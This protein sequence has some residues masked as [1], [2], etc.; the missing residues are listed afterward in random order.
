MKRII[1]IMTAVTVGWF[2]C[3]SAAADTLEQLIE[4]VRKESAKEKREFSER[5]ERF[6]NERDQQQRLLQEAKAQLEELQQRSDTL[7]SSYEENAGSIDE[8]QSQLKQRMGYLD[9][10]HG[11][12]R[13]IASDIQASLENSMVS[14]Q[15][16]RPR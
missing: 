6:K 12:I 13:Q 10:L 16:T 5:V 1:L 11:V 9:E 8:Q 4:Q 14:A 2:P 3:T 15:N 7:R